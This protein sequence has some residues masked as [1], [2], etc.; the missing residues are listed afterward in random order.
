[1]YTNNNFFKKLFR[2][3]RNKDN[4]WYILCT[5]ETTNVTNSKIGRDHNIYF[6]IFFFI[7]MIMKGD[8]GSPVKDWILKIFRLI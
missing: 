5:F 4:E 3:M 1:M 7:I 2:S 8:A 6:F